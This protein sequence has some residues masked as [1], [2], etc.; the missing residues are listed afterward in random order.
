[1]QGKQTQ[2]FHPIGAPTPIGGKG[3]SEKGTKG[4]GNTNLTSGN[5]KGGKQNPSY[6]KTM[7]KFYQ[8]GRCN[9][10]NACTFAHN[11]AEVE[12]HSGA[13]SRG[14]PRRWMEASD[15]APY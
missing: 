12:E 4:I 10:G 5:T 13:S 9:R 14:G 1:M 6:K 7:C 15:G 11:R 8:V 3:I 2:P